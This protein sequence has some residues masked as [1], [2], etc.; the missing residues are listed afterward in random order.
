MI[1]RKLEPR[2]LMVLLRYFD[3][4]GLSDREADLIAG[5]DIED[6]VQLARLMRDWLRPNF[7][8]WNRGGRDEMLEVLR[9]SEHWSTAELERVFSSIQL[10][11]GQQVADVDRFVQAMRVELF[12]SGEE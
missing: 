3:V 8:A 9:A 2:D 1:L 11:S 7:L 6:D 5:V 10:P 4:N 12:D